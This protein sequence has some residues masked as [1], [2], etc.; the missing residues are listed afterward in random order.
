[1]EASSFVFLL[2]LKVSVHWGRQHSAA[3]VCADCLLCRVHCKRSGRRQRTPSRGLAHSARDSLSLL[4]L[5]GLEGAGHQAGKLEG[6]RATYARIFLSDDLEQ[7]IRVDWLPFLVT[8][9]FVRACGVPVVGAAA[10]ICMRRPGRSPR[11]CCRCDFKSPFR[12]RFERRL[13]G[14]LC[15]KIAE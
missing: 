10:I 4:R 8:V 5:S 13:A 15:L 1:M 9:T 14:H 7:T 11:D 12:Q 6:I 2:W 3:P